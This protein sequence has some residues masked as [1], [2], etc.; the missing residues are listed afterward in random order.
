[1]VKSKSFSH[2]LSWLLCSLLLLS[3]FHAPVALAETPSK[4]SKSA[5]SKE[6]KIDQKLYKQFSQQKQTTFLVKFKT[7]ANTEK[8]ATDALK[9]AKKQ[10]K[11]PYQTKIAKRSS[12]VSSLRT[13]SEQTQAP[14]KDF[15]EREK[16]AEKV[17]SYHSFYIVNA[18]AVTGSK[19]TMEKLSKFSEVEKIV[20]N[21]IRKLHTPVKK[22][23]K[24]ST[25]NTSP[26]T[27]EWN[28]ER[29]G[30]PALWEQGIDGTGTVV[31]N[32]DT[33]VQ[34]DHPS[35]KEKYRGYNS[36]QP[37]QP[38]HIFNW[39]DAVNG[40][41]TPYDDLQHGT[42]T[43]GTMVGSEPDG[44]NQ[45]GVAPGAKWIAVKAFSEA[46]GT[47][48]DLL[49]AGEWILSPTDANGNPHP[50]KAPDVVNNSWGGGPGLDEFYRPMVQNWRSAEIFPEFS[51]GNDGP[52][53]KTIATPANYPESFATGATD[54]DDKL[55]SFS[56]R[57]SSPYDDAIKPEIS[58]PGVNIR[59]AIPGSEYEDGWDGTSMAGPH[60]SATVAL[61]K[62]VDPSLTVDQIEEILLATAQPLTDSKYPNSPNNGYGHGLLDA[63]KAIAAL[64]NGIGQVKG[65]VSMEG[66]DLEPPTY[67]H[68]S[69]SV[70]Y[71]NHELPLNI[72]VKDN[73]SVIK[74][75]LSYLPANSKEWKTISAKRMNGD[76]REANYQAIIPANEIK[77]PKLSYRWRITD[78]GGNS[79]Q[80]DPY[81]LPVKTGE[82]VGYKQD[83]ENYPSGWTSFGISSTWEWGKPTVGPTAYSGEKVFATNL[84]GPYNLSENSTLLL[85]PIHVP[86]SGNTYLHYK[87][88]FQLEEYFDFG[89][90]V[91]STDKQNWTQVAT[92]NGNSV[93]WLDEEINLS[94]YRGQTIYIGFH[95]TSDSHMSLNGWYLDDVSIDA[96]PL[97]AIKKRIQT[98]SPT[99]AID[100]NGK[101]KRIDPSKLRPSKI[102]HLQAPSK[103]ISTSIQPSLLPLDAQVSVLETG[104]SVK[105]NPMD[106]SYSF[107]H[108]VGNYTLLAET[109]GYQS[110]Q[111]TVS[112]TKNG[113]TSA[114]FVMQPI[115]TGTISGRVTDQTNGQPIADATLTLIEDAAIQ[116][117]KTDA[118]GNFTLTAY[119]GE[120]TLQVIS[121]N[122]FPQTASVTIS[123]NGHTT[124]N[125]SLKPFLGYPEEI[126]YDDG[127]A[128]DAQAFQS[129]GDGWGVHMSLKNGQ[130]KAMVQGGLFHFST[131]DWPLPGGDSFQVAVFDASGPNGSPGKKIAGPFDGKALRNGDWTYVDLS[132][133]GIVVEGDFYLTYIQKNDFPYVP[134]LST[135]LSSLPTGRTWEY[136]DGDWYQSPYAL[137][138][139]MIRAVVNYELDV[140]EILSP[141][142]KSFTN[143]STITLKGKASPSAP[144]QIQNDGEK[145][146]EIKA[147]KDGMFEGS[148]SLKKG[149]NLL[150]ATS[151]S[152]GGTTAPSQQVVVTLDQTK[153]QLTIEQPVGG[154]KTN[155]EAVSVIGTVSDEHL[156]SVKVN[157]QSATIHPDGTY[158]GR[159]LLNEGKNIL[160]VVALDQAGNR[161][162]KKETVYTKFAPPQIQ[163]LKPNQ[164]LS[165]KT[166]QTLKI[167]LDSDEKVQGSFKVRM[168]L[169]NPVKS[170]N[171]VTEFPLV[172]VGSGHYV[173][174]W[175][176]PSNLKEVEGAV[177][178]VTL[179]DSFGNQAQQTAIGKLNINLR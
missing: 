128:E 92:Y 103:A 75:E 153:P 31:A 25:N 62:Q 73:I 114:N 137:G 160:T 49:K 44:S 97:S 39:F 156:K 110:A 126:S 79:V 132:D 151:S 59:S 46:G 88:Y 120:Y 174:Y 117:V 63:S 93:D 2:L 102:I 37:D 143:Q 8:V 134:G 179:K 106:G 161:T 135:D 100:K 99:Q 65:V 13:T 173:G 162:V 22:N 172:E 164:D 58:A 98:S 38:D 105:T 115:P 81:Q 67:E 86:L 56:S 10:H 166:G 159:T 82:T 7:Q 175:T 147:N 141:K 94:D 30:V 90:V 76:H 142:N 16:K 20:P 152:K 127:S 148:I 33:G 131:D 140:P 116:P 53:P 144:I 32:I 170:P 45:I 80:S 84:H 72:H 109:Y 11:S 165:L 91:I 24:T 139:F 122:F 87:N 112:I 28:I 169:V 66:E 157:G 36:A 12:V 123:G 21:E 48:F 15:L 52:D 14:I 145:I 17:K 60:V 85:P 9:K 133:K 149:K 71:Q 64:Q 1:M 130:K 3:S 40:Q 124:Q 125:F 6:N 107:K 168:P 69:P 113:V 27:I 167:E 89:H 104:R 177:V 129:Y 41:A 42:H 35:L 136:R 4:I 178:E 96:T 54:S 101:R 78:F 23:K 34:W 29:V 47:D 176:V 77:L 51:A 55:A 121:A 61:M 119:E 5:V 138:N 95:L 155:R 108:A 74:V 150:T 70:A 154:L 57:G 19:E 163:N 18:I 43:M 171:S 146:A 68:P 111:Q 118:N 26:S 158:S 83:F 50:E